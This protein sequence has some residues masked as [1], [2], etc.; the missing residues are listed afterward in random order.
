MK[1]NGENKMKKYEIGVDCTF[2]T[3]VQV[4]A[5]D[6]EEAKLLAEQLAS[7]QIEYPRIGNTVAHY[8]GV[9]SHTVHEEN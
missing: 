8:V 7:K 6:A 3:F 2:G 4:E 1:T 5:S 9:K